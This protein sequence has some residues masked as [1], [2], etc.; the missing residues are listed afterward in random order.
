MCLNL[1]LSDLIPF[2]LNYYMPQNKNENEAYLY[3][4]F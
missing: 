4:L 3:N 1:D 2:V